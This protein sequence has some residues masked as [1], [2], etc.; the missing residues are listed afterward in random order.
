MFLELIIKLWE[1]M[2][3]DNQTS[4]LDFRKVDVKKYKTN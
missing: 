3:E 1:G 4:T 2:L